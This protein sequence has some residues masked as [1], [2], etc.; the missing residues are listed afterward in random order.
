MTARKKTRNA[1]TVN[2]N[3]PAGTMSS[4]NATIET[5]FSNNPAPATVSARR[6]N[7][8]NCKSLLFWN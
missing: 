3:A 5:L 2:N 4:K 6:N 1:E 8:L 7:D